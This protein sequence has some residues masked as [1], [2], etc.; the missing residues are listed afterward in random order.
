M[1]NFAPARGKK[2]VHAVHETDT[3]TANCVHTLCGKSFERG[4]R[5]EDPASCKVCQELSRPLGVGR[6]IFW[7]VAA[8][9]REGGYL[10][11]TKW[12]GSHFIRKAKRADLLVV[13]QAVIPSEG[14]RPITIWGLTDKAV[15]VSK[16]VN[17]NSVNAGF[18]KSGIV[19]VRFALSASAYGGGCD[20][21]DEQGLRDDR[22]KLFTEMSVREFL[23]ANDRLRDKTVTC[24]TC[25]A[26]NPYD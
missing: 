8:Y 21:D 14:N 22:G 13:K 25:L 4:S 20:D 16:V 6:R 26:L 7:E 15:A 3:R 18:G 24:M 5:V 1:E 11:Y 19:H 17:E 9:A 10:R 2:I 12:N 23:E